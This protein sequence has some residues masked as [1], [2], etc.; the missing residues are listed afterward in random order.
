MNW[1]WE[2]RPAA[3]RELKKLDRKVVAAVLDELD[4]LARELTDYGRPIQA[5]TKKLKGLEGEFRLR[6]GHYRV[7]Y[8]VEFGAIQNERD[9]VATQGTIVV[10]R[11][12]NRKEAY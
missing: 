2:L 6:V 3:E 7:R 4:L 10:Y 11:V 9:A 12:A 8:G 5:D 1:T